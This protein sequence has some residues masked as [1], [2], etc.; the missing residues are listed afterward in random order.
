LLELEVLDCQ[1][2]DRLALPIGDVDLDIDDIELQ[3][4][5][6][7]RRPLPDPQAVDPPP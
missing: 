1:M 4:I 3:A 5:R 6:K 7:S 2:R